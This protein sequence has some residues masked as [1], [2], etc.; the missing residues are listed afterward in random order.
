MESRIAEAQSEL[1]NSLQTLVA[2]ESFTIVAF[3]AKTY[4]FQKKLVPATRENVA[5]ARKFLEDLKLDVQE[6]RS[7][8]TDLQR[9]LRVALDIKGINYV[10]VISDGNSTVGEMNPT[11]IAAK[12]RSQN[13]N[14]ARIDTIGL[15]ARGETNFEAEPL[16]QQIARESGGLY[17]AVKDLVPDDKTARP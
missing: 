2:G 11:V 15:I 14:R 8:G 17:R 3:D 4:V 1:Q 10:E 5:S 16:L 13:K 9:A 7:N 12:A 6:K